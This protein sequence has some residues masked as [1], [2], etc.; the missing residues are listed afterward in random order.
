MTPESGNI[1]TKCLR[2]RVFPSSLPREKVVETSHTNLHDHVLRTWARTDSYPTKLGTRYQ[3][4]STVLSK[5]WRV[6]SPTDGSA[7]V[8][9]GRFR[10]E[11]GLKCVQLFLPKVGRR[12]IVLS[13]TRK[14]HTVGKAEDFHTSDK[15]VANV[16]YNTMLRKENPRAAYQS[17]RDDLPHQWRHQPKRRG[18][19]PR[20]RRDAP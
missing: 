6:D 5:S 11:R 14:V 8:A 3:G 13:G 9:Q 18:K 12:R 2:K 15:M 20:E 10:C 7:G 1:S 19:R 4:R 16:N 17:V